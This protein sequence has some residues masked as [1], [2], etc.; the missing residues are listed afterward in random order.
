VWPSEIFHASIG[1]VTLKSRSLS[2]IRGYGAHSSTP[3]ALALLESSSQTLWPAQWSHFLKTSTRCIL[4]KL[5]NSSLS[6][7][8]KPPRKFAR[9]VP[10]WQIPQLLIFCSVY[11][12]WLLPFIVL[13]SFLPSFHP[14]FLLSLWD[15]CSNSGH[16]RQSRGFVAETFG[17]FCSDYFGDG[18]SN[19]L[20]R[21]ALNHMILQSQPPK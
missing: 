17:P 3:W 4:G 12:T 10:P 21:L 20:L 18:V 15:W 9:I 13:P 8:F 6:K 1:T 19:Y 16:L 11:F 2:L 5:L 14:F 7:N